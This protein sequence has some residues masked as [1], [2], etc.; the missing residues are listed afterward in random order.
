[1]RNCK[2]AVFFFSS[3]FFDCWLNILTVFPPIRCVKVLKCDAEMIKRHENDVA[4]DKYEPVFS[5]YKLFDVKTNQ[6]VN[7]VSG[8]NISYRQ[9]LLLKNKKLGDHTMV[10]SEANYW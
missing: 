7:K 6:F 10:D 5:N 8:K 4:L 2:K 3:S 1:M 9:K